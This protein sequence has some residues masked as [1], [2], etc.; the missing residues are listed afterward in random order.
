VIEGNNKQEGEGEEPREL[1]LLRVQNAALQ[2][3]IEALLSQQQQQTQH[4]ASSQSSHAIN[5]KKKKKKRKRKNQQP[6]DDEVDKVADDAKGDAKGDDVQCCAICFDAIPSTH[7]T[8]EAASQKQQGIVGCDNL[9]HVYCSDCFVHAMEV[10]LQSDHRGTFQHSQQHHLVCA[11]CQ[12]PYSEAF[13]ALHLPAALYTQYRQICDELIEV[14]VWTKAQHSF[15]TRLQALR[16]EL[17]PTTI[18][19]TTTAAK[20][21]A[22]RHPT[23]T[24]SNNNTRQQ[25]QYNQQHQLV[26]EHRKHIAEHILTLHCPRCTKAMLDFDHCFAVTFNGCGCEFCAW[27]LQDCGGGGVDGGAAHRHVRKCSK[28]QEQGGKVYS[29]LERFNSVHNQ[30][31]REEV[32]V[33]L[34]EHIKQKELRTLVKNAIAK[35]LEGLGIEPL[36]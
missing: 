20:N 33:Y 2:A 3:Q 31:R 15:E 36:P 27:C 25:E 17:T 11:L 7:L 22:K 19:T 9:D 24:S 35:D 1:S 28:N 6:D 32:L 23:T 16:Q 29:T 12:N 8:N 34:E 14:S 18:N 13:L 26:Q 30:R 21:S 10:Q 4:V 5:S